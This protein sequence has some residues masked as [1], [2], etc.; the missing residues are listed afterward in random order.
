M[1]T[2]L[3]DNEVFVFG[4]NNQGFHG[5][6]AAAIAFRYNHGLPW[7]KDGFF[8]R[9]LNSPKNSPLRKGKWA[10]FGIGRGYS[11]GSEGRSYAIATVDFDPTTRKR[12]KVPLEDIKIQIEELISFAYTNSQYTFL[13]TK[14]GTGLAGYKEE[15]I[16][17]IWDKFIIPDNIKFV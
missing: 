7:R 5:S 4:S 16:N 10:I 11:E 17:D 6:G 2:E 15:E 12:T 14:F 9:A 13:V 1:I 3:K 8:I